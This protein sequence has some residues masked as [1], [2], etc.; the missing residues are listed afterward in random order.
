MRTLNLKNVAFAIARTLLVATFVVSAIKHLTHWTAALDEMTGLGMPRSGFL[1]AGS[2][3]LRLS[4]GLSVLTGIRGRWGAVLLLAF[5]LPATFLGHAFW[6]MP[7]VQQ[8]HERVEF[9]N[10]LSMSGGVLFVLI[11]GTAPAIRWNAADRAQGVA[12]W[13]SSQSDL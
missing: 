11:A 6:T 9:L 7:L 8:P 5:V 4:G 10:N 2:I 12:S 1:M 3:V 13:S